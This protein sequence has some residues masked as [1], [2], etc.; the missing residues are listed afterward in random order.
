MKNEEIDLQMSYLKMS[1]Q[2][3]IY[4]EGSSLRP[5]IMD[6]VK[7]MVGANPQTITFKQVNG[8]LFKKK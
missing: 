3:Y 5:P 6:N 2:E 4:Y 8:I 7:W 1:K